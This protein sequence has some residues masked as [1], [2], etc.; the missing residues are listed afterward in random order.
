MNGKIVW[1]EEQLLPRRIEWE[2][3]KEEEQERKEDNYDLLQW[4]ERRGAGQGLRN[5]G[6]TCFLN[7][8]LQCLLHT[9][10]VHNYKHT[11]NKPV[12]TLCLLKRLSVT[13][14]TLPQDFLRYLPRIGRQ[15]RLGNQED[16]HE[17]LRGVVDLLGPKQFIRSVFGGVLK[18]RVQCQQCSFAS[19]TY[20]EFLDLS[21]ELSSNDIQKC[22][23]D[24]CK[25]ETLDGSNRYLCPRCKVRVAAFK[26]LKIKT[27][28][29]ILSLHL[30]RFTNQGRK[31]T[32]PVRY[33]EKLDL[34]PCTVTQ[35]KHT[36]SL[37]AVL[38][39]VGHSCRSGHYFSYIKAANDVWYEMNDSHVSQ[40]NLQ[41]AL[42]QQSAYIL[43]YRYTPD[44]PIK[45]QNF[46]I[47]QE[48]LVSKPVPLYPIPVNK[49]L[50]QPQYQPKLTEQQP[51]QI[52]N[53]PSPD[54]A[55]APVPDSAPQLANNQSETS[56]SIQP[57]VISNCKMPRKRLGPC[58]NW[59]EIKARKLKQ[60]KFEEGSISEFWKREAEP[61]GYVKDEYD[62]DLDRG[63]VKKK[64]KMK[65]FPPSYVWDSIKVT[66]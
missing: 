29:L 65:Q 55:P 4:H 56:T 54:P 33:F 18:S 45:S 14:S 46:S 25:V 28:P 59:A 52:P 64:K 10:P 40:T 36:Y 26:Q 35:T 41:R 57:L 21:L 39:H 51:V 61:I 63:K 42:N 27:P 38:V 16:A 58:L 53:K 24:F 62:R 6:N 11:C 44:M 9:P 1:G 37:Y 43:F 8:T 5:V 49:P 34:T 13:R 17:L 12:C 47:S 3:A 7:S 19:E 15:F 30:K 2:G 23:K 60:V 31:D 48:K 20:D 66:D 50:A 22:L 32:R